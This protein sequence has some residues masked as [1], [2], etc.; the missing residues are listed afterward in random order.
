MEDVAIE[1]M[2]VAQVKRF[3][4]LQSLETIKA[5]LELCEKLRNDLIHGDDDQQQSA[6]IATRVLHLF[7]S[8][9]CGFQT[10]CEALKAECARAIEE[11]Q[12]KFKHLH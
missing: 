1:E 2:D 3:A 12:E 8:E 10:W 11:A 7:M 6:A 5:Y 4:L 9:E